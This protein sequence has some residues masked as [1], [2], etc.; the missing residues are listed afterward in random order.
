MTV[1]QKL[2]VRDLA[3]SSKGGGGDGGVFVCVFT[4]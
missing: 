2:S 4:F 1:I 3:G